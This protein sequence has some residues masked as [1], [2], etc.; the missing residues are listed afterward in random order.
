MTGF[1]SLH[2]EEEQLYYC[3]VLRVSVCLGLDKYQGDVYLGQ[4]ANCISCF[5][6]SVYLRFFFIS[7]AFLHYYYHHHH[8]H[9]HY[10]AVLYLP[11]LIPLL[12][13]FTWLGN[14][15]GGESVEQQPEV[16]FCSERA[17]YVVI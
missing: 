6:E 13:L 14:P 2:K 9:H 1:E 8:H 5:L 12:L 15:G 10:A 17:S 7:H 11:S 16:F 3:F 4:R